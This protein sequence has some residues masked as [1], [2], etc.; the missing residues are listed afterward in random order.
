MGKDEYV[1][2]RTSSETKQ[3]LERPAKE[4]Y[5]SFSRQCEMFVLDW[6]KEKGY[7]ELEEGRPFYKMPLGK[8]EP[9]AGIVHEPPGKYWKR[10]K[11]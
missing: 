8:E 1:A 2:F 3:L 7:I 5:R 6:L 11:K 4:D 9:A 10:G